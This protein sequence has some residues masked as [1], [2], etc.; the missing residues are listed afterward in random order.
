MV[1]VGDA[2]VTGW[3]ASFAWGA[4]S[5]AFQIEGDAAGRGRSVWDAFCRRP[6]AVFGGHTGNRACDHVRRWRE[7]LALMRRMGLHAYRFSV[8]WPRVMPQG[9]GRENTRGLDFYDRLVDE[10]LGAH[11]EPWLTLFHWDYPLALYRRGGWRN[12]DSADWFAE[13]TARVADR[14][15]DRVDRW[16]TLNEPQCFIDYGHR[17]GIHA[18]GD[19]L[20]MPAVL[21]AAHHALLAHGRAVQVLR[22]SARRP[23]SIGIAHAAVV[24]VPHD[25]R[26][27]QDRRAA[28]NAM[29]AVAPGSTWNNVWW[30]DPI[31]LGRP[32][33]TG[34]RA[35]GAAAADALAEDGA[36][37]AQPLDFV[38]LNVYS[39]VPV[40]GDA[41]GRPREMPLPPGTPMSLCRWA[42]LPRSLYWAATFFHARYKTPVVITE[43]GISLPDWVGADGRVRDAARIDYLERYLGALH[44]A[45]R[46]GVDVR[47][48]FHWTLL[49]NFEWAEGYKERFGLVHVDFATGQRT[50]KDSARWYRNWIRSCRGRPPVAPPRGV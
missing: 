21:R 7:D 1:V 11:I 4:A 42:V 17:T 34:R 6:G 18:P 50:P 28:M 45:I 39:G 8:S 32:P 23:L 46:A 44:A 24:H 43:N 10:L 15:A 38:G 14:L 47:G 25:E 3:P 30:S 33:A 36:V 20:P 12:R 31:F 49:D 16:I 41:R 40:R 9:V 2:A 19:R 13:Y 35:Y 37:I 48:Y 27:E 29:A 5:S 26:R 22:A